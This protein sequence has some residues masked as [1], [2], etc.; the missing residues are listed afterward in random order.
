M[1]KWSSQSPCVNVRTR[2]HTIITHLPG[3]IGTAKQLETRCSHLSAWELLFTKEVQ[4]RLS[5][6]NHYDYGDIDIVEFKSFLGIFMFSSV[7][8]P[9]RENLQVLFAT[10][11]TGQD[12]FSCTISLK[13]IYVILL[14][15]HFDN[16]SDGQERKKT[17][18]TPPIT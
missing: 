13:R 1:F 6:E 10:D 16:L 7:F 15:I 3:I 12:I 8:K 5:D 2:K 14:F 18:P 11:G 9:N 4:Q 17:D